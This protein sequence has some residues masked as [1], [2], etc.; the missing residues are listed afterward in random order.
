MDFLAVLSE[1]SKELLSRFFGLPEILSKPIISFPYAFAVFI[2]VFVLFIFLSRF[3]SFKKLFFLSLSLF[4]FSF[5]LGGLYFSM[6]VLF[7][8]FPLVVGVKL[9]RR[10]SEENL[11]EEGVDFG[12][13]EK[14]FSDLSDASAESESESFGE[15]RDIGAGE[16]KESFTPSLEE[17]PK[18]KTCPYCGTPLIWVPQYGRYY[19]PKCRRYL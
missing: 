14:E 16:T 1:A 7:A 5:L 6:L 19:C 9:F 10:K 11:G 12:K 13:E 2:F 18:Q 15:L 3:L 8:F 4:A 17:K